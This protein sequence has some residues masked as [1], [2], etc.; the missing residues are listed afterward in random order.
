MHQTS[1]RGVTPVALRSANPAGSEFC[2]QLH[3]AA[4]GDYVTAIEDAA[5]VCGVPFP[6]SSGMAA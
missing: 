5:Q 2:L 4:M 1:I 3:K 6:G